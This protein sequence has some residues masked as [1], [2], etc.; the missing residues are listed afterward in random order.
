[1][2]KSS[3][4]DARIKYHG[5]IL[6]E[7]LGHRNNSGSFSNAD[8]SSKASSELAR[9][10]ASKLVAA[11]GQHPCR[12][13]PKEQTLGSIFARLTKEFMDEAFQDLHHLRPGRWMFS[14]SQEGIGI[15]RYFQ[16]EP[17]AQLEEVL[18]AHP[19]LRS[20]LGG[21]YFI[22]PDITVAR[23]P[24]PDRDVN[25]SRMVLDNSGQLARYAPLRE[26]V[27]QKAILHASISCKWTIRSDRAQNT[28]TEALNLIR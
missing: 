4:H 24:V 1:M 16:Y 5:K 19:K 18:T 23:R 27:N 2:S 20:T 8:S 12:R 11:T 22:T 17:L 3:L 7:I 26:A 28:R 9:R 14:T 6:R 15:A 10:L 25:K 13:L 21:D